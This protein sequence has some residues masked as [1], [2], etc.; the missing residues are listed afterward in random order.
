MELIIKETKTRT[1]DREESRPQKPQFKIEDGTLVRCELNGCTTVTIPAEVKTI[2]RMCFAVT[3][4][5]EVILPEGIENIESKAF[6]DCGKLRKINFPEGL[7]TI[8]DK[9]FMNCSSLTEVV[10]PETLTELGDYAFYS[11]GIEQL[12][13]PDPKNVLSTGI[14]VFGAIKIKDISIPKGFRLSKAMFATCQ[15]LRSVSF[16]ADWVTIP[17]RCFY[18]CTNLA[19]IDIS[20]ALFIKEA[21]F[22]KCYSLSVNVIPA[23]TCV[24]AC[25]F[26]ETGV[27]D[28]TIEDISMIE[29]RAFSECTSLKRLTINV[30]DGLAVAAG[31]SIPEKL[32]AYCTSLQTITFTGHTENLSSI[33]EAAFRDT[34]ALTE[35][36]LPDSIHMIEK[37]A[38]RDSGIKNIH[39]P[40]NLKQIGAGA[41]AMSK[42]KSVT[43]PDKVVKLG[44]G[45]F[46]SCY[47]LTEAA[48]PESVTT[49]PDESFFNCFKLKIVHTSGIKTIGN[50]AFSH[51]KVLKAFN[52]SQIKELGNMS[53][54]DTGICEAIFSNKLTKLQPSIFCS[55]KSLQTVDMSAC[56]KVK[57]IPTRCFEGCSK[58]TDVKL[59]PNVHKFSDDCFESV[60]FDRLVIKAGTRIDFHAFGEAVI[61]ELEFIDDA[62]SQ[63]KT[64]VDA[65]AFA[66]AKIGRLVIPDYMYNRFEKA[67]SKMQ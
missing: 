18:Y 35:I 51:C 52:F 23:H 31:L 19:E 20:K 37:Y 34:A 5:E 21:A 59:P 10:L 49:I 56:N 44:K 45:V 7:Q 39:L 58:L 28:V 42:L 61:N 22:H 1:Y 63:T 46:N 33:K 16:E 15:Q 60:K 6:V 62:D 27:E 48:L 25:A 30:P 24:S 50:D 4:V 12:T 26:M 32:A 43:I 57:T 55:C 38:F 40:E 66:R 13:L 2:G 41:F 53:F 47:G 17:E 11:A 29:E 67:I 64:I 65:F 3:A 36:N 8:K 54:S 9:S 14:N